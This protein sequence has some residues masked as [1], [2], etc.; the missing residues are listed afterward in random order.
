MA[1]PSALTPEQHC[2]DASYVWLIEVFHIC[3]LILPFNAQQFPYTTHILKN[4]S[5]CCMN[6]CLI[7]VLYLFICRKRYDLTRN[8]YFIWLNLVIVWCWY[9]VLSKYNHNTPFTDDSFF[10]CLLFRCQIGC[11][12][13][14]YIHGS[15]R[16]WRRYQGNRRLPHPVQGD[17]WL[18]AKIENFLRPCV[19]TEKILTYSAYN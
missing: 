13:Q 2:V 10:I 17:R 14:L 3:G 6:L 7:E 11:R 4:N 19:W 12:P 9:T 15:F 5:S 18:Q 1:C 8:C 16:F